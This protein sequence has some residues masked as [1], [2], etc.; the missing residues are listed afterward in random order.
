MCE[1]VVVSMRD[2][3]YSVD[4]DVIHMMEWTILGN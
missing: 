3:S 2:H 1:C 4:I